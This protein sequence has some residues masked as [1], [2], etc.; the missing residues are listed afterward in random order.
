MVKSDTRHISKSDSDASVPGSRSGNRVL[1]KV[2]SAEVRVRRPGPDGD[3]V[4]A[5]LALGE[6]NIIVQAEFLQLA[7][8]HRKMTRTRRW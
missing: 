7:A 2:L 6:A 8:G 4:H 1:R 3:T 5:A